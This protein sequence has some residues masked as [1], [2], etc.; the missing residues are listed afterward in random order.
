MQG[1]PYS[2]ECVE[3]LLCGRFRKEAIME[4]TTNY[5]VVLW[6]LPVTIFIII[7]LMICFSWLMYQAAKEIL[8]G[9]IPFVSEYL[10]SYYTWGVGLQKRREER[11]YLEQPIE[12]ELYS[13]NGTFR[14]VLTNISSK[15]FCVEKISD[16]I[17]DQ[18]VQFT[19][20][21]EKIINGFVIQGSPKW[22]LQREESHTIGF[23]LIDKTPDWEDYYH[24]VSR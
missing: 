15:G 6:L 8:A 10:S 23:H 21:L 5:I 24:R 20:N 17:S 14:G 9:R 2:G 18:Y 11:H 13:H 16:F 3:T 19:V 12:V 1:T 7:P 22:V 4:T